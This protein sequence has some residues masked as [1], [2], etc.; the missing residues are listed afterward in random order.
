LNGETLR[1]VRFAP[2][3][4]ATILTILLLLLVRTAATVLVLLFVG[5]L[6]SLYLRAV[7]DWIEKRLRLPD[8]FSYMAALF[9]TLASLA[10]LMLTLVPP[11]VH[12]MQQLFTVLPNYIAGWETG[13]DA[14]LA[15][16]PGLRD[17]VGTGENR[18]IGLI[19]ERA[20]ETFGDVVPRAIGLVHGAINVFAV[21]VMGI[22]LSLHPALYR[23]WLIALFPPIHRDLVRDVLGDLA[24]TL[25]SWI[26]AMLIGMFVLATLTAIGLYALQVPFWSVFGIFTG[27]VAIVPFFGTLLSTILPALFVLQ[28]PGYAGFGPIGHSVLVILLGTVVHLVESNVVLPLVM[29]KKVDLPPVLTIVAVLIMGRLLGP[30]GLIVAVPTLAVVMVIVRRI[31]ITR[32]YEGQGFRR[33]TRERPMLL[34][35]PAPGGGVLVPL[36]DMPLDPISFAEG[37]IRAAS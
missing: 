29:S 22:Y 1:R 30:M 8:P 17:V 15:K 31:L 9:L 23:E 4:T 16:Y 33:T 19:Y 13:L 34:R 32:I 11:V 28:G 21:G 3:L 24:T 10:A 26:V 14:L 6:I 27:I 5:I 36:S 25:R 12:Q 37:R 20:K 18:I 35:V 7:A 2:I